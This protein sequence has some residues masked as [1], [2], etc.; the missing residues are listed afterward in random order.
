M[1]NALMNQLAKQAD[2]G[3]ATII[4]LLIILCVVC[5]PRIVDG[6]ARLRGKK[7]LTVEGDVHTAEKPRYVSCDECAEHRKAIN[8]RIDDIGPA[9]GRV[10]KKLD[11]NDKKAEERAQQTHR[12]L[13]PFI[14]ELG[15]VRGK[16]EIIEKAAI[17][18]TMGGK[19]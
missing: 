1:D 5:W 8:A 7:T 17:N 19:K 6:I 9:L 10:F 4:L 3:A 14:Q 16:M 11:E 2:T 12:R 18:S 13:D 15:A